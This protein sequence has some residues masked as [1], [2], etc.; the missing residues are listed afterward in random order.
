MSILSSVETDIE[1]E[2]VKGDSN[3]AHDKPDGHDIGLIMH[4]VE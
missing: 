1:D 2:E 3:I 4:I